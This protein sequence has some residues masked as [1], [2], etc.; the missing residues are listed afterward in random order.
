MLT[1][2]DSEAIASDGDYD[3]ADDVDLDVEELVVAAGMRHEGIAWSWRK[4]C[5]G[6][7]KQWCN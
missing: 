2:Y 6:R 1:H 5:T 4:S 3:A 7:E